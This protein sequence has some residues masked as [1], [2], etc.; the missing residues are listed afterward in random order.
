MVD[1]NQMLNALDSHI[2]DGTRIYD[3]FLKT[4][5]PWTG[6]FAAWLTGCESTIEAIYGSGS[7]ALKRFKGYIFV[8]PLTQSFASETERQ[9]AELVWFESGLQHSLNTLIGYRYSLERLLPETTHPNR[10][11]FIS[12]GGPTRT[13]VDM[14]RELLVS[15]GLSPIIV[16]DMPNLNLSVHQKVT[17]YM[18]ICAAALVLATAED[19]TIAMETRARPNVENEIGLLQTSPNIGSRIIYLKES[20]V[21]FASNYTEKVWI[22][23]K[24]EGLQDAFIP[25]LKELRAFGLIG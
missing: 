12:H 3:E 25:L 24:K 22:P 10:Y 1:K 20:E 7:D 6:N 21:Q 15:V 9:N 14:A 17:L 16:A 4:L 23:F 2:T 13:H 11:V 19:E 18:G 8:P 5:T